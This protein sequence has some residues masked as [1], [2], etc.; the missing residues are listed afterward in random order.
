MKALH[1]AALTGAVLLFYSAGAAAQLTNQGLF[2]QV[3]TEFATRATSWQSVVMNAAMW[4]FWTL[5]T[6]SLTW[7][8]GM[9]ILRK[10]DIGDFFA[11]FV[12]F[13]MFFGFFLW[14]LRNGPAFASSIIQS[15]QRL[16]EQ[17]SGVSSVTPSGIVDIGFMIF[18]QS[19]ANMS[20]WS[21]IDS[22]IGFVLSLGIL[23]LLATV[24]VNML[25]LFVSSWILMYAGVFFL[26]FGG[27]RWTSDMAINYYKTVL[28]VAVQ[29]FAMVLLVGIGVDLLSSF[30]AKM[31]KGTLNFEELGVMLVFCFALLMLINKIPGLLSGVITGASI[32]HAGIGNFGA[33]AVAGAALGAAG[34]AATA[35]SMAGSAVMGGAQNIAGG[36]SAIKAAFE[37]AAGMDGGSGPMPSFGG[38][39]DSGGAS[40]GSGGGNSGSST[41]FAQAAGFASSSGSSGGSSSNS[42]KAAKSEGGNAKGKDS[43][44][45]DQAKTSQGQAQAKS[46]SESKPQGPSSAGGLAHAAAV[47]ASAAGELAKGAGSV[48]KSKAAQLAEGFQERASQ[49]LGGQ[50][51]A[52]I[53]ASAQSQDAPAFDGNSLGSGQAEPGDEVAAFV[54][55]SNAGESGGGSDTAQRQTPEPTTFNQ[56]SV[57]GY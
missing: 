53:R 23:L 22:V 40:S 12:R 7:T 54:N 36:M 9:M 35:A 41:P 6:I 26:G 44:G 5:G 31:N 18:K 51:A 24:G 16:G 57:F 55:R 17:A 34:M 25:L 56:K 10:A 11:E 37:K 47:T 42:A 3:V 19:L 32:G 33:G 49:T 15:L 50:V 39:S 29:L 48:L 8:G 52:A 21:P 38:G 45:A 43:G 46:G 2:D 27:S 4:L 1:K 14:L 30:Y 13:I 20:L 28:G